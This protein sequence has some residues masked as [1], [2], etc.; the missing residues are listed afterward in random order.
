M[1]FGGHPW[2]PMTTS[3][4]L[5]EANVAG[6]SYC[7]AGCHSG[8]SHLLV[9]SAIAPWTL[10]QVFSEMKLGCTWWLNMLFLGWFHVILWVFQSVL[11]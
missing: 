6:K 11:H 7:I 2:I 4:S 8:F 10:N 5:L 9:D 3:N 1:A